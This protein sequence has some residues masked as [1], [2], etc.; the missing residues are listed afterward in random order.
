MGACDAQYRGSNAREFERRDTTWVCDSFRPLDSISVSCLVWN[1][2]SFS[3]GDVDILF[4]C[5][6]RH[7]CL[8]ERL[9]TSEMVM[10][11]YKE[12][13]RMWLSSRNADRSLS[14]DLTGA[15]VRVI[16]PVLGEARYKA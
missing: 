6:R 3:D 9:S 1:E 13:T 16:V 2:A 5:W 15:Y 4:G 12:A 7:T 8:G 11:G 10:E 14:V